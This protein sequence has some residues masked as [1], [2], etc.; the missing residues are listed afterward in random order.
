MFEWSQNLLKKFI[1]GVGKI[2]DLKLKAAQG[3]YTNEKPTVAKKINA[4]KLRT[5]II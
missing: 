2:V 3:D 1:S 4:V 5:K